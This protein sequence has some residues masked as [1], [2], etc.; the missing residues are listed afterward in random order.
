MKDEAYIIIKSEAINEKLDMHPM[1][2]AKD[3][4]VVFKNKYGKLNKIDVPRLIR[5]FN[6]N[7]R[8]H[9]R[10]VK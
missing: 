4:T 7:I 8:Q 10:S 3:A 2:K 6:N 1:Y 9:K 5:V